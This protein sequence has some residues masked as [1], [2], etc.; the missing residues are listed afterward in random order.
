VYS[1]PKQIWYLQ[2]N[3]GLIHLLELNFKNRLKNVEL[4]LD[5]VLLFDLK[6]KGYETV[7]PFRIGDQMY[8]LYLRKKPVGG[9]E[10]EVKDE[11]YENLPCLIDRPRNFGKPRRH[12]NKIVPLIGFLIV[13]S[14]ILL[15]IIL[16]Y[17]IFIQH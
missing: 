6:L 2:A 4:K 15:I 5:E 17:R 11:K 8:T 14:W 3:D 9:Y 13:F 12:W 7:Y 1:I 10:C 16:T